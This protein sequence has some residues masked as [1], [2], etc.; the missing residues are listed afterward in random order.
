MAARTLAVKRKQNVRSLCTTSRYENPAPTFPLGDS[1]G[2]AELSAGSIAAAKRRRKRVPVFAA[3]FDYFSG[4]TLRDFHDLGNSAPFGKQSRDIGT[5]TPI[6]PLF[7]ILNVHSKRYFC[8][9]SQMLLTF[10]EFFTCNAYLY[11]IQFQ[12]SSSPPVPRDLS[13]SVRTRSRSAAC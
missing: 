4:Q 7:Q 5:R 9:F 11:Y 1:N 10:Y 6:A 12:L 8:N 3:G 2:H 13:G